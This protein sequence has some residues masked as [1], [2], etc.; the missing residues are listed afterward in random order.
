MTLYE[1]IE[2]DHR[3]IGRLFAELDQEGDPDG[4]RELGELESYPD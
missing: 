2:R 3:R 4:W 1:V